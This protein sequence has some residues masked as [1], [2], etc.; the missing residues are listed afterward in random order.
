MQWLYE[1]FND[2]AVVGLTVGNNLTAIALVVQRITKFK[3]AGEKT[4]VFER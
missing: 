4:L 1:I 2:G 3:M